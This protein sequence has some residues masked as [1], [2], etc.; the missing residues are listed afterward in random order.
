MTKYQS[1]ENHSFDINLATELGSIELAIMV[2]HFQHW[3][4][5]NKTLNQNHIE[6]RTWTY[7]TRK[8]IAS[9]FPYW[10]EEKVRR[11]TDKLEELGIIKKGNFN[12]KAM[13]KTVW[14]SFENEE[15]FT[16][17]K[18]AKSSGKFAKCIGKNAKA[19]P[20]SK[21]SSLTSNSLDLG[22]GTLACDKNHGE[23]KETLEISKRWKLTEEQLDAFNW[24]I[25][26]NID[27]EDKKLAFWAKTYPLQRL[28]DVYNESM[29]NG[30]RSLRKYMSNILDGNKPVLN[31]QIQANAEFA[32]DFAKINGWGSL[33]ICKKYVT[34]YVGKSKQEI[35]L[36]MEPK[37]FVERLI[38]KYENVERQ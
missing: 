26:K 23:N 11:Y 20:S 1:S 5:I 25:D 31:A 8:W 27:A 30:A 22:L 36:D 7:Q 28:I 9:H 14:Y 6:G 3:I 17:G 35:N 32:Q 34:F 13:D 33:K 29:H 37:Y 16:I 12:K 18:F 10:N 4:N 24:L 19:I 21:P 15:M 2:R 38:Q